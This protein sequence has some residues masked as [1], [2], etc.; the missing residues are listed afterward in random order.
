MDLD[1]SDLSLD[2]NG[3][4]L[5]ITKIFLNVVLDHGS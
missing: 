2:M 4:W 3:E 5:D 1:L